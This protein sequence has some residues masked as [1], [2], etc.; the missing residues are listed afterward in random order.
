MDSRRVRG[1]WR[2]GLWRDGLVKCFPNF[3]LGTHF[4]GEPNHFLLHLVNC[5]IYFMLAFI[6]YFMLAL[7]LFYFVF[8]LVFVILFYS[9]SVVLYFTLPP[10]YCNCC[11]VIS[12]GINKAS[13]ILNLESWITTQFKVIQYI[14]SKICF[15]I[16]V[17]FNRLE[18]NS[19]YCYQTVN[20]NQCVNHIR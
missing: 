5:F 15:L 17:F 16:K 12:L 14:L 19:S 11:T 18:F 10:L 8:I 7:P 20:I 2:G 9:N 1:L 3:F 4:F 6:F 13:W